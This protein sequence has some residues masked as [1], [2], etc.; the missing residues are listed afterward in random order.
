MAK[1]FK[2]EINLDV[3]DST[4]TGRVCG[5]PGV[6]ARGDR[7]DPDQPH[8]RGHLHKG[9]AVRHWDSLSD[10]EKRLFSRMAEVYAG[11]SEYTDAQAGRIVDYLEESGQLE[12]TIIFYCADNAPRARARPTARS[13]RA[14]SSAGTQTTRSRT[15]P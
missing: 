12:N 15:W 2:G 13:T 10:E 4:R 7:A 1:E 6:P 8:A 5:R 11:F 9:D 14:R 3:R